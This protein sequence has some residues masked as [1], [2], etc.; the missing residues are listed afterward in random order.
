[1]VGTSSWVVEV[2]GIL[3]DIIVCVT[4]SVVK[5]R[6]VMSLKV[7]D[8]TVV[9]T[10]TI[11]TGEEGSRAELNDDV[12]STATCVGEVGIRDEGSICA[13]LLLKVAKGVNDTVLSPMTSVTVKPPLV[14]CPVSVVIVED[15]SV[16]EPVECKSMSSV[17]SSEGTI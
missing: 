15:A 1:M 10:G 12:E 8:V 13:L 7:T 14:D 6:E 4:V 11:A 16:S 2:G 9:I 17:I 3:L 5:A